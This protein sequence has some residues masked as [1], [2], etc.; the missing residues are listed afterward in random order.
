LKKSKIFF[1]VDPSY[2][3][4]PRGSYYIDQRPYD[5]RGTTPLT[6]VLDGNQAEQRIPLQ[7]L[8]ND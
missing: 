6:I 8:V 5:T 4:G 2:E 7:V 1:F 3:T